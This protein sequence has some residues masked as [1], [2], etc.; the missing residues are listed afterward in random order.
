[1]LELKNVTYG[2]GKDAPVI[3]DF[4]VSIHRGRIYG[5]LGVNAAG[6][7]TLLN[8]MAGLLFPVEGRI[9]MDGS[10][11]TKREPE[12]L[13][14]T[15]LM[16]S[17]FG[18]VKKWKIMDFVR[19]HSGF[20]PN[21][22]QTVL[23]DCLK[24]FGIDMDNTLLNAMSLGQKHKVLFSILLSFGTDLLLLDE[25]LNGMDMPSRGVFRKMLM[26]HLRDDQTVIISSHTVPDI[27]TLLSDVMILREDGSC[28]CE[29]IENISARY[30]FGTSHSD[31]GA[32]YSEPCAGGFRVILGNGTGADT[33][34]EVSL[35]LLFN[36]VNKGIIK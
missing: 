24:S 4:S 16:S 34:S 17:E 21:F 19:L 32:V 22:S 6:K 13:A 30:S 36:A 18:F 14:K 3:R 10:D 35:E 12:T 15:A 2:Y 1:M 25:P 31:R 11:I 5:L 33:E 26:K 9:T 8:L 27:E 29:T 7:T 20:Y 28:F 23:E